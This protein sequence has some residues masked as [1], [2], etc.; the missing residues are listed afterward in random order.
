MSRNNQSKTISCNSNGLVISYG[1][2]NKHQFMRYET[3]SHIK[4]IQL[5]GTVKYQK[6]EEQTKFS[7][8]QKDLYDKVLYGFK[9]YTKE[10]VAQMSERAKINV[11]VTYTKAQRI[12]RNWKQ[13]IT[14]SNLDRFLL[15]LF[16][17]S[18]IVK[19]M[20]A[21]KGHLDE[22][23]K[24]DEISF[25]DLGINQDAIANKLIEFGLLPKNFYQLT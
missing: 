5:E 9:A 4:K 17:K 8:K 6:I 23:S 15:S 20:C 13:D 2:A 3:P 24:E 12:L 11:T 21:T 10:E 16:P 14:F 25:K 22:I 1:D 19:A 7:P 18:P